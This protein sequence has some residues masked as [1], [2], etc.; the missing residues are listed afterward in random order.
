MTGER[1][2]ECEICKKTFCQSSDLAKHS[3][4][5][6]GEKPYECDI[7]QKYFAQSSALSK[8]NKTAAH[9]ER[10]KSQNTNILITQSSFVDCGESI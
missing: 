4:V 3:R 8:H 1:P 2:Y 6:T 10:M 5:H 9:I 7:C